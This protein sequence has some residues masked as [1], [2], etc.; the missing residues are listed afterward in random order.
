MSSSP[1][2]SS[3]SSDPPCF[4]SNVLQNYVLSITVH[5]YTLSYIDILKWI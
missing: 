5:M 4:S 1:A 3:S 2:A